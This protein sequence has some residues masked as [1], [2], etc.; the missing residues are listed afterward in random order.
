MP[1]SPPTGRQLFEMAA[2]VSSSMVANNS[3]GKEP[4]SP[5]TQAIV[6]SYTPSKETQETQ[7]FFGRRR[8]RIAAGQDPVAQPEKFTPQVDMTKF[9]WPTEEEAKLWAKSKPWEDKS[10]W[11]CNGEK[12]K[13]QKKLALG[14]GASSTPATD[15]EAAVAVPRFQPPG[16]PFQL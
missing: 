6:G 2:V 16:L 5:E 1:L 4:P 8:L 3:D 11:A 12:N 7:D 15:S 9:K 14:A 10:T 13:R